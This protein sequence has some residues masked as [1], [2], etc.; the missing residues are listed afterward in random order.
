MC[1]LSAEFS[2][3]C[4]AFA[5]QPL[6][7]FFFWSQL[8]FYPHGK[9]GVGFGFYIFSPQDAQLACSGRSSLH[10]LNGSIAQTKILQRRN[11]LVFV[12]QIHS[13]RAQSLMRD[14]E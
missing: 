12:S 4:F 11:L 14:V 1:L 9:P 6:Q 5:L 7:V 2:E 10:E 3:C 8:E 13:I